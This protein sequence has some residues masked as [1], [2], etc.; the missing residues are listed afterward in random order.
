MKVDVTLS[1]LVSFRCEI[2]A[3]FTARPD[4]LF[5]VVEALPLVRRIRSSVEVSLSPAFRRGYAS[6][7][8]AL[9]RGRMHLGRLRGIFAA[10]EP[11]DSVVVGGYAVYAVDTTIAPRPDA[12]TLPDRGMQHSAELGKSVPGYQYSWLVRVVGQ[13]QSW[14]A[15]RDVQRVTTQQTAGQIGGEQVER[16]DA[17]VPPGQAQVVVGDGNYSVEKFLKAFK[18]LRSTFPLVRLRSNHT[19]Y[20]PP[21]PREPHKGGRPGKHGTKVSLKHPPP[22]DRQEDAERVDDRGRRHKVRLSAWRNL[23]VKQVPDVVGLVL[24]IEVLKADGTPRYERPLWLF[25]GG[26][27]DMALEHLL[28]MYLLRFSLEH[29]FR[30]AK[31]ELG[32]LAAHS[33]DPV[34]LDNWTWVVALVYWQLLLARGATERQAA[35]WDPRVRRDPGVPPTPGQVLAAWQ[36]FSRGLITPAAPPKGCGKPPGRAPGFHPKPRQRHPVVKASRTKTKAA[37]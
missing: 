2:R 17:S 1:R 3:S 13:G 25:W 6:V 19:L 12:E 24:R 37:A 10:N 20:G 8:D 28:D 30:F 11:A 18:N 34:A 33:T 15:P 35:P 36:G 23:H 22:P 5:E 32:L 4:A 21:K 14:V 7:Y 9:R 27:Q 31:Q 26:D 29:F 16:L